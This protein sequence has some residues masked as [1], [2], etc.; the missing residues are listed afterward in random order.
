MGQQDSFIPLLG[1]CLLRHATSCV[2]ALHAPGMVTSLLSAALPHVRSVGA[3]SALD[4]TGKG[5]ILE[6]E[7]G[8]RLRESF[9]GQGGY[10]L[11]VR[12]SY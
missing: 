11:G 6:A 8:A 9:P 4:R 12:T 10:G 7:D 2:T 5:P 1:T 3:F